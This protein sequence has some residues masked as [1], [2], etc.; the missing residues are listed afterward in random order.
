M[1]SYQ[2]TATQFYK[3]LQTGKVDAKDFERYA[4]GQFGAKAKFK[5]ER[6]VTEE[7]TYEEKKKIE[8]ELRAYVESQKVTKQ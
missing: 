4:Y 6:D 5:D 7:K 8:R 1:D 3:D 2:D